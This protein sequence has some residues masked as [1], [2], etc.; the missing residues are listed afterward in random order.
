MAEKGYTPEQVQQALD[1]GLIKPEDAEYLVSALGPQTSMAGAIG[2]ALAGG[3][4]GGAV[5]K[6]GNTKLAG[7]LGS[8]EGML[9]M[10]SDALGKNLTPEMFGGSIPAMSRGDVG[11]MAL[12]GLAGGGGGGFGGGMGFASEGQ[13]V[14]TN[15]PMDMALRILI[16]PNAPKEQKKAAAMFLQEQ[17]AAAQAGQGQGQGSDM[18][19]PAAGAAL[20]GLGGAALGA[21]GGPMAARALSNDK[22]GIRDSLAGMFGTKNGDQMDASNS[23]VLGG[24]GLGAGGGSMLG[25]YMDPFTTEQQQ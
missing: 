4:L 25:S 22:G 24:V 9:G 3:A 7:A 10:K 6:W 2:G 1:A 5:G 12:G 17:E 14:G 16:D 11:G 21:L 13:G 8:E 20:G 23:S 19:G 15:D 18:F